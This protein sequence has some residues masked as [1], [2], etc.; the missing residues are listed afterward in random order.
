MNDSPSGRLG[1][2]EPGVLRAYRAEAA[3][4]EQ[5]RLLDLLRAAA[6]AGRRDG[7]RGSF[8]AAVQL[9][10]SNSAARFDVDSGPGVHRASVTGTCDSV[11]LY[12]FDEPGDGGEPEGEPVRLVVVDGAEDCVANAFLSLDAARRFFQDGL[13]LVAEIEERRATTPTT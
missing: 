4:A 9:L 10:E 13:D 7:S 3:R 11:E 6:G 1:A 12:D 5:T 8:R 2:P